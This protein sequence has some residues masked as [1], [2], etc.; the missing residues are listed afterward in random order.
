MGVNLPP[1][2]LPA[3]TAASD[4]IKQ[5]SNRYTHRVAARK[6][7]ERESRGSELLKWAEACL[8]SDPRGTFVFRG[9]ASAHHIIPREV[10]SSPFL[11]YSAAPFHLVLQP[12]SVRLTH[13]C[14]RTHMNAHARARLLA[15]N[16]SSPR[17]TPT[18]PFLFSHL[19]TCHGMF[20]GHCLQC[21]WSLSPVD[22][23]THS[24]LM[25]GAYTDVH[26]YGCPWPLG[27]TRW[28]EG[29]VGWRV[30]SSLFFRNRNRRNNVW[31]CF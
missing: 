26:W 18:S 10:S 5:N 8:N 31:H 24:P 29:A 9:S 16:P 14:G 17:P 19:T 21:W 25:D 22:S 15:Y 4:L 3:H 12:L 6:R 30:A 11:C 23:I 20:M 13:T 28:T 2:L 1:Q 7:R 27:Q